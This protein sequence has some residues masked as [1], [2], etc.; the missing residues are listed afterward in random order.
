[1]NAEN[2]RD[3][4]S[5]SIETTEYRCLILYLMVCA[6]TVKFYLNEE[7]GEFL[8]DANRVCPNFKI[9]FES[10]VKKHATITSKVNLRMLNRVYKELYNNL[11]FSAVDFNMMV[12]SIIQISPAY[13]S[14]REKPRE[15]DKPAPALDHGKHI[16]S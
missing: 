2:V 5:C 13:T 8:D 14:D 6:Y 12:D 7:H 4:V 3:V 11:R 15:K 16:N 1:M 9:I 10:W